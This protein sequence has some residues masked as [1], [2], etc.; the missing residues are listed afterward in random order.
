MEKAAAA[1]RSL[2]HN[3]V[4]DETLWELT[5]DWNCYLL[6]GQENTFSRDP[7]NLSGLNLKRDSGLANTRAIGI[8]YDAT[9]RKVKEKNKV[10]KRAKVVRFSLRI[11]THKRLPK[12]KLVALSSETLPT[13]NNNLYSERSRIAAR[14]IAKTLLR[15]L[16]N[17]RRDLI[18]LAFRKLRRLHRFKG[19]NKR[20][21]RAEAK[22]VKA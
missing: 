5:R 13:N 14:A 19:E 17:Y 4:S 11:K 9:D 3:Q 10:K 20:R 21:N 12:N 6:A 8:G 1:W 2:P 15:D 18:P 7:L 22:K 16:N